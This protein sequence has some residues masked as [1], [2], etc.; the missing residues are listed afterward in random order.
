MA[1]AQRSILVLTDL[2]PEAANTSRDHIRS[3]AEY[4]RHDIY[5]FD[6][7]YLKGNRSLCFDE[8]D[9]VVI[10]YSIA[11]VFDGYLHDSFR[12]QLRIYRGLKIVFIQDDYRLINKM[13]AALRYLGIHILFTLYSPQRISQVWTAER[14]PAVQ[15]RTTLAGYVPNY[16]RSAAIA[17][18]ASRPI[19]V[20]YRGRELP[21]WLGELGQEKTWIAQ[22]FQQYAPD[23]GLVYDVSFREEDRIYGDNWPVFISSCK[24]MLG[25]ESGASISDFDGEVQSMTIQFLIDNPGASFH[26]VQSAILKPY[27]DNARNNVISPRHFECVALGTVLVLFP[28]EYSG[29]LQPWRHYIPLEKDFS[30]F[31]KVVELI[32]DLEFLEHLARCSYDDLISSDAYS[33]RS[34]IGEFD[35]LIDA[36][37]WRHGRDTKVDY[38]NAI[39]E[40]LR[41]R[42]WMKSRIR[43]YLA[44]I[45]RW[46]GIRK[47]A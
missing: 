43:Q 21:F 17:P 47:S 20:G 29:I 22:R 28:G 2:R 24:T 33:Y 42:N 41:H 7:V 26:E 19:D 34:F 13:C 40:S 10:H 30:N 16:L 12:E 1:S 23:V 46:L 4:S 31:A 27:E 32:R 44:R 18:L 6:P 38:H 15:V 37:A 3:F 9:V 36:N 8:F 39:E 14:L 25:T 35:D 5:Y 11:L 45:A